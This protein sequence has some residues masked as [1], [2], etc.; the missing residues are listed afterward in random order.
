VARK[1]DLSSRNPEGHLDL[2]RWDGLPNQRVPF[3]FKTPDSHDSASVYQLIQR[4]LKRGGQAPYIIVDVREVSPD[5]TPRNA[6]WIVDRLIGY[7]K[8]KWDEDAGERLK[9]IRFIGDKYD[10]TFVL[11]NIDSLLKK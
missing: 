9:E 1:E 3:E 6:A 2:P 10:I 7:L 5:F 4:S 8:K 11:I